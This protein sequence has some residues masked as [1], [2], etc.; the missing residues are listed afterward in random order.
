MR[1]QPDVVH[2]LDDVARAVPDEKSQSHDTSDE[3]CNSE[4]H[5]LTLTLV[6]V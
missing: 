1:S 2:H 4:A 3:S 5:W 6:M